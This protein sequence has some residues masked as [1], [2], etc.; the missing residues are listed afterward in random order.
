MLNHFLSSSAISTFRGAGAVSRNKAASLVSNCQ[1]SVASFM[2]LAVIPIALVIGLAVDGGL[3]YATK[4]KLQGAIDA[5]ALA[6]ARA[7]TEDG[8]DISADATMF[9]EA[10]YPDDI[11]GGRVIRF[12]P[13]FDDESGEITIDAEVEIPTAFMKI[14][15]LPT[16][17]VAAT[18]AAQQQLSGLELSLVLDTTGSMKGDKI[19][20]LKTA[21]NSLLNIIY[22]EEETVDDVSV[23][24]VPYTTA[25]NV[26]TDRTDLLTGFDPDD[27]GSFGW[28]GC[29]EARSGTRDRDDTP[30]TTSPFT[31]YRFP[32]GNPNKL[33]TKNEVLPLTAEKSVVG[34]HIKDLIADGGT[35]NN[36]GLSWGW[37]TISP[38]WRG[39][40]GSTEAPVDYDHPTIAKAIIFMTDGETALDYVGYSSYGELSDQRLGTSNEDAAENEIDDRML[41]SCDLIKEEGIEVYTIMFALNNAQVEQN[42]RACASSDEHFFDAPDGDELK[43]AFKEIAGQLT[44]LRLTQ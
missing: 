6:A 39:E 12:D 8:A 20:D 25:V 35:I 31:A 42:F 13:D 5:A 43:A 3:A 7:S 14:A 44:S 21:A 15:G 1:G 17:T 34:D 27:F 36:I 22:G 30:P 11:F 29:V 28:G 33:C 24:V 32:T 10:N 38:R 37:R 2:G 40:W 18:T 41:E 4:N 16:V 26:G 23:S 19:S 9:F